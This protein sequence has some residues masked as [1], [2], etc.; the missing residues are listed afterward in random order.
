MTGMFLDVSAEYKH[1]HCNDVTFLFTFTY[2]SGFNRVDLSS[3]SLMYY[4]LMAHILFKHLSI[5]VSEF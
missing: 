5:T 4:A 3:H 2:F 1:K